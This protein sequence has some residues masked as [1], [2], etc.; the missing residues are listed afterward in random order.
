[1]N[2]IWSVQIQ[3]DVQAAGADIQTG[4]R[5]RVVLSSTAQVTN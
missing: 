3:M 4:Q 5:P 2:Q 1:L